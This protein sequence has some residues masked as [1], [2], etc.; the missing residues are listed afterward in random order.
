VVR[1]GSPPHPL[2]REPRPIGEPVLGGEY[3]GE[4]VIVIL[5]LRYDREVA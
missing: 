4:G 3:C 2:G 5:M 1:G